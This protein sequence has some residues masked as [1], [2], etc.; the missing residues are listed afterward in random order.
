MRLATQR[1]VIAC[2]CAA[3][4]AAVGCAGGSVN[5]VSPSASLS[6]TGASR[7]SASFPRSGAL[8][9]TKECSEYH[10]LAGEICTITSSNLDAIE[11]GS[12]VVYAR[13]ADFVTFT[14]DSDVVLDLPGPGNNVAFG[15][16]HL[17][18][19]TG[20]GLCTFSGGTGKFTHFDAGVDVSPP[21]DGLNWHWTGTYSF[22]PRD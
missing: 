14:L 13:A 12:R 22:D 10:G 18:L 15:H 8:H 9:V 19:V 16:C 4:L 17:N 2:F 1:V 11:V 7:A 3:A 6:G 20:I 5:P 21:T